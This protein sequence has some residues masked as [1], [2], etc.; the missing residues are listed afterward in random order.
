MICHT[1]SWNNWISHREAHPL[2]HK[3]SS[4]M[5]FYFIYA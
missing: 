2:K 4:C 1:C 3:I 5:P